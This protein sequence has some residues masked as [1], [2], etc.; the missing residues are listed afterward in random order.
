MNPPRPRAILFDV[1]ETLVDETTCWSCWADAMRVPRLTF[2]TVPGALIAQGR[3]HRA[4]FSH[5]DPD[6]DPAREDAGE[7]Y[8]IPATSLYPDALP[9]IAALRAQ[10]LFVGIAGNQPKGSEAALA[11]VGIEADGLGSSHTWGVSKPDT[12]F[13]DRIVAES[14]FAPAEVVHVGDRYDNDV[15]PAR[16]AGL[17]AIWLHRGPWAHLRTAPA[18]VE[19][20]DSLTELPTRLA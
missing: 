11:R 20:I 15:A 17:R 13:F 16:A 10:G 12:R 2:F 9:C 1:G 3:S 18:H 19:R 6:F 8:E 7:P 14:G 4:V 5:F